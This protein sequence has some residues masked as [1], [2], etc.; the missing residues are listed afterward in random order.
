MV[1]VLYWLHFCSLILM[2]I[3]FTFWFTLQ[4]KHKLT[5]HLGQAYKQKTEY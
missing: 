3:H 1:D 2:Q 5:K 4:D